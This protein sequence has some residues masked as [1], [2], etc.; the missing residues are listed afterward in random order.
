MENMARRRKSQSLCTPAQGCKR[1]RVVHQ[2]PQEHSK[3]CLALKLAITSYFTHGINHVVPFGCFNFLLLF[4]FIVAFF[5]TRVTK[6]ELFVSCLL[7]S[8]LTIP[9]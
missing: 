6:I 7:R 8:A 2:P 9:I 1:S 4:L 3:R 5:C